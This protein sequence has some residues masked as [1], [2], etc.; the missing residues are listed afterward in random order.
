MSNM[1]SG[2]NNMWASIFDPSNCFPNQGYPIDSKLR[3]NVSY[4]Y[5]ANSD[6]FDY[7][8][9]AVSMGT[10][11]YNTSF[12][13]Y[14]IDNDINST[15]P[16]LNE[17][18]DD[19]N[20]SHPNSFNFFFVEN[21]TL[22]T[23]LENAI[24]AGETTNHVPWT[25]PNNIK[26]FSGCSKFASSYN[27]AENQFIVISGV[28]TEYLKR[29]HYG[30]I[31]YPNL[32]NDPSNETILS[33]FLN[34]LDNLANHELG[35][36]I[37]DQGHTCT[38]RNLMVGGGCTP[39]YDPGAQNLTVTQLEKMH[40]TLSTTNNHKYVDCENL[41][42][43]CSVSV[44]SNETID[45]PISVFGDLI[46]KQGFSLTIKSQVYLST[47]SRIIVE[48]NAKLIVD[49]GKLT[50]GC[51]STWQGIKVYGGNT[52]FDV[53]F[54]NNATIENTTA[55]AVS[56]FAPEPWPQIKQWGNGILLA[57]H[58]TFNNT[59]RIVELMAW[60]PS[61][62]KSYI[63]NCTQNGGK[64]SITNWNCIGVEVKGNLF[65]NISDAC[66][67]TETGQFLIEDNEFHSVNNDILFANVSPGFGT[68]I[69]LNDF[70]GAST[71]VRAL[72]TTIAQ[73]EINRNQFLTGEF[74]IFMD[75]VNS[76]LIENNDLTS[77][78]GVISINNGIHSNEVFNN[79]LTGNFIG[80][81]PI[82]NNLDYNF[83]QNCFTTS[84][85]DTYIEGQVSQ[86][87]SAGSSAA[88]NCFTHQGNANSLV[89]DITGSPSPFDYVEPNDNIINCLDAIKAGQNVSRIM[90]GSGQTCNGGTGGSTPIQYNPCNP[91]KTIAE[92]AAAIN[93]L[94]AKILEVQ[95]NPNLTLWQKN[96]F[97]AIY[98]RCLKRV[99]WIKF[100][101]LLA[102]GSYAQARSLLLTDTS[103][104]AKIAIYTSYIYEGN[105]Q[106]AA[107]YLQSLGN[108]SEVLSDFKTI[109]VINLARLPYGPFYQATSSELSTVLAIAQKTHPY[110][111]YAKALYYHFTGQ[112]LQSELPSIFD[113]HSTPRNKVSKEIIV[114]IY[115]NPFTN[116]L[117]IRYNSKAVGNVTVTD[118]LGKTTFTGSIDT[119]MNI[120][121]SNWQDGLYIVIITTDGK[122]VATKKM[123][124]IH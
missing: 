50:N 26:I 27:S 16:D 21:N 110:A 7:Y 65:K 53:K 86:I 13:P 121:T 74:D 35:H 84:F 38:C 62:N 61:F 75:G 122:T 91:T 23:Y 69:K 118:I 59:R 123:F 19:Y 43:V 76:Y 89:F 82:G 9:R 14:S 31:Y 25:D 49:G 5:I 100:E 81:A 58:T 30:S 64:W 77:D 63:R 80:L 11:Y 85:A 46:I 88:N 107:T 20:S 54:T 95:N 104:E 111:G 120:S 60:K 73:N 37:L 56:M 72:G 34:D 33:W 105:L 28:Y 108:T 52:D 29:K 15:W 42:G 17:V 51:G 18:I 57:D 39:S 45:Q 12:C 83:F 36:S 99:T 24:A 22:L 2:I 94:N 93:W 68:T 112:L 102:E 10:A 40:S 48:P 97:I 117:T 71:G 115:P 103:D 96:W 116:Q 4:D 79:R 44:V 6:A 87:V 70:H 101:L 1:V 47:D 113:G 106:G 66:I 109:Q 114:S 32:A 41:A 55:A 98:R 78:F 90:F 92:T 8:G 67:V 124:L 3:I 119:D